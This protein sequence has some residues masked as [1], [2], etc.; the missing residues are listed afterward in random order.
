MKRAFGWLVFPVV[1]VILVSLSLPIRQFRERHHADFREFL[2]A[3]AIDVS[4]EPIIVLGDSITE[5][6]PLPS[7]V[8]G[9]P[10]V[11]AGI[12]GLRMSD[13]Y[14][15]GPRLLTRKPVF[16]VVVALGANDRGSSHAR[17]DY[18]QLMMRLRPLSPRLIS[19]STAHDASTIAQIRE[20]A[21]E[22]EIPLIEPNISPEARVD[23]VHLNPAGYARWLP[24]VT[25]GILRECRREKT[26]CDAVCASDQR[27]ALRLV[28]LAPRAA[29]KEEQGS[30]P[31][32]C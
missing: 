3:L 22:L 28:G 19:V 16:L 7:E 20:A 21:A 30:I 18:L 9:H 32:T 12:G 6:T 10:V 26:N 5:L 23:G 4:H 31:R 2:I 8:C 15:L 27:G 11:N 24:A 29:R 14:D 13:F 25:E 1:I 17:D